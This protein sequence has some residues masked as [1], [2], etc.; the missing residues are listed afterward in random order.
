MLD[1]PS[2]LDERRLE[3]Q[4]K[5]EACRALLHPS[6]AAGLLLTDA[7]NVSWLTGGAET[8]V[9]FASPAS[10]GPVLVTADNIYMCCDNIETPRMYDEEIGELG[11]E[12]A[13]GP[14]YDDARRREAIEKVVGKGVVLRDT[15]SEVRNALVKKQMVMS[16]AE[17]A[18]YRLLGG[19]A[20]RCLQETCFT[21]APGWT[22]F[23]IAGELAK[24]C[25]DSGIWPALTLV[26]ADERVEKY[27][28]P[29]ATSKSLERYAMVVLCARR[30]GL[31]A[32]ATRIVH[33]GAAPEELMRKHNAVVAVDTTF[34]LESKPGRTYGE[35]FRKA[36]ASYAEHGFADEWTL[37]H[38]GGPT[39]YQG[40]YFKATAGSTE[41]VAEGHVLAWNPSITGTKSEDTVL[42]KADGAEVLTVAP[43]WP[44]C[45]VDNGE[46]K[47][48][49]CDILVR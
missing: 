20:A 7:S 49:R 10:V 28:H 14:W 34:N 45:T 39:G 31:I 3:L 27:R 46:G 1:N 9:F 4:S 15:D 33:F 30:W 43:D 40:R 29:I 25:Y 26:A 44:M 47:L 35:V 8:H 19:A 42:V 5:A 23:Q 38:Q 6:G 22:E 48:D 18:R 13:D 32:N 24:R 12:K 2:S 21:L 37:H 17:V 41:T 11:I 36:Q 16:E